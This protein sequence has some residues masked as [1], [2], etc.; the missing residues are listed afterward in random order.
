MTSSGSRRKLVSRV[1]RWL[2]AGLAVLLF[3]PYL[4]TPLY[5]AIDPVSTLM[6]AR[7]AVGK[8]VS[9][10][11]VPLDRVAPVLSRS[12]IASEDGRF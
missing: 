9:R 4:L 6:V 5:R 2:V 12:V 7:W 11:F 3:V 8:R 10:I 1:L